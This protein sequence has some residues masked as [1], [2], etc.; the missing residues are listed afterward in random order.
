MYAKIY[1]KALEKDHAFCSRL[2]V[3][4][5]IFLSGK[6]KKKQGYIHDSSA[7][8]FLSM[9]LEFWLNSQTVIN[10]SGKLCKKNIIRAKLNRDTGALLFYIFYFLKYWFSPR[11]FSAGLQLYRILMARFYGNRCKLLPAVSITSLLCSVKPSRLQLTVLTTRARALA[12][13]NVIKEFNRKR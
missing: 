3:G 9:I 13:K 6:V 11:L 4:S 1:I 10:F 5:W 12:R 7:I 2:W 8:E